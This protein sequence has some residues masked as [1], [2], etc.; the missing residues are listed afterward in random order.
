M[1]ATPLSR[2]PMPDAS[3]SGAADF[4]LDYGAR[5]VQ[6][7]LELP[8]YDERNGT[9]EM[10][11]KMISTR[12]RAVA[13]AAVTCFSVLYATSCTTTRILPATS[14]SGQQAASLGPSLVIERFLQAANANDL[15]TMA[16]LF[17][18]KEGPFSKLVPSKKE[19]DDRMFTFATVLRHTDFQ[20]K[21]EGDPVS[22]RR[23]E[24]KNI[25]VEITRKDAKLTVPFR[26]V[27]YKNSWLIEDL[28]LN[29]LTSTR[30]TCEN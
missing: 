21:G 10:M 9:L 14:G 8:A 16:Q 28:C 4:S 18:T 12:R 5:H 2:M 11:T 7:R 26:M 30:T 17:G 1:T 13:M 29:K 15:D 19:V 23:N 27:Q 24:A 3:H 6:L 25:N 20:V 22:G